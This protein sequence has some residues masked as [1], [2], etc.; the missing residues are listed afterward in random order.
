MAQELEELEAKEIGQLRSRDPQDGCWSS[1]TIIDDGCAASAKTTAKMWSW[2]RFGEPVVP[3][4][5]VPYHVDIMEKLAGIDLDSARKHQRQ[6]LLLSEGRCGPAAFGR[7]LLRP[8]FHD[9]P[10]LYLLYPALYDPQQRGERRDELCR[11]GEHDVQDRG[12]GP[13][14]DRHQR[15]LHDRQVH[16]YHIG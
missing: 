16:R 8:G 7:A 9:R 3:D 11:N 4:F 6:R 15:A 14:S 12:G 13:L 2:Q 1:P 10:G 5:E